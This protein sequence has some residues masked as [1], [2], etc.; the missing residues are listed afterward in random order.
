MHKTQLILQ[1]ELSFFYSK[2]RGEEKETNTKPDAQAT[3]G[4][5]KIF[6]VI[7]SCVRLIV[8]SFTV[9]NA[10]EQSVQ[11]TYNHPQGQQFKGFVQTLTHSAG[12]W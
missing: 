4:L 1:P 6:S 9:M 10:R 8:T 2:K 7:I 12:I 5:V 3:H 11:R